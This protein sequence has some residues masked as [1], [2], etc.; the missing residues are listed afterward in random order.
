MGQEPGRAR[1]SI[2]DD[3]TRFNEAIDQAVAESLARF[4]EMKERRNRLFEALLSSSPDLN[5]VLE[6]SGTLVYA[7]KA[8]ADVFQK[9][10]GPS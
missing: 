10:H 2:A 8:F 3:I 5:Y 1:A 9:D 4:T 6:P 7:N